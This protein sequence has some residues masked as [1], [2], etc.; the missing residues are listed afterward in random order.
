MVRHG[1]CIAPVAALALIVSACGG[2][3]TLPLSQGIGTDIDA[4]G[5]AS[6]HELLEQYFG[7][8]CLRAGVPYSGG[9]EQSLSCQYER[10][11]AANWRD[12]VRASLND[13]DERCDRY[14]ETIHGAE[15]NRDALTG[16]LAAVETATDTVM[17]IK[18]GVLGRISKKA[19]SV[20]SKAFGLA[21]GTLDN[22]YSRLILQVNQ[23]SLRG[24][25]KKRQTAY[26]IKLE[27][28]YMAYVVDKPSA[29]YA[30]RGYLRLCTPV[31]IEAEIRATVADLQYDPD[32]ALRGSDGRDKD[33]DLEFLAALPR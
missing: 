33:P 32:R 28:Q 19:I 21:Q 9:G 13:V 23:G 29:Y 16:Q 11:D 3:A 7:L 5:A 24:L 17:G 12:L 31:S 8:M 1:V 18:E 15:K 14:I 22:V 26:R 27:G 30:M 4:N 2:S 25:I 10:L 6:R 20:V